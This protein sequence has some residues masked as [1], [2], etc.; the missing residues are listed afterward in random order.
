[1]ISV[2]EVIQDPDMTDP[3]PYVILRSTGQWVAGGFQSV[4]TR[5][6]NI[7]GPVRNAT[8]K[9]IAMLPEADRV[10]RVRAF[11]ATQPILLAR[12][13]APVPATYEETPRQASAL[14]WVLSAPP[15]GNFANITVNGLYMRPN[16]L[17][18]TL[19]G[20]MIAFNVQPPAPGTISATWPV[21]ANVQAAESDVIVYYGEQYRVTAVYRT[22]GSGY[23][24]ALATRMATS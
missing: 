18:Y 1:M 13:Y 16:G 22:G 23:W 8:D 6:I 15:P 21:T 5:T 4:V 20:T 19:N 17:D 12:G 11:Y 10:S 2:Q 24:K 3:E 14:V 7:F 9:E